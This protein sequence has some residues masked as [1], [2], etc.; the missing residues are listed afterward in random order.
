MDGLPVERHSDET[1]SVAFYT[2][3]YRSH[4]VTEFSAPTGPPRRRS[5]AGAGDEERVRD[6][7]VD[8]APPHRHTCGAA[9][10][11]D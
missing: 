6:G 10:S 7:G 8:R 3:T 4:N 5:P 1:G 11:R 9:R 2:N